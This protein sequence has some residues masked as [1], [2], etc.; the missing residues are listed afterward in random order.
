LHKFPETR[1]FHL[2]Y[3]FILRSELQ[4]QTGPDRK[5]GLSFGFDTF[6]WTNMFN[7]A[8]GYDNAVMQLLAFI[9][10]VTRSTSCD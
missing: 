10:R 5:E 1:L 9:L 4:R 2:I 6:P 8:G 3:L 7:G